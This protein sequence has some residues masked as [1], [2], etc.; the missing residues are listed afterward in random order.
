MYVVDHLLHFLSLHLQGERGG[1]GQGIRLVHRHGAQRLPRLW[2]RPFPAGTCEKQ[3]GRRDVWQFL[4]FS[5]AIAHHCGLTC[6]WLLGWKGKLWHQSHGHFKS[7]QSRADKSLRHIIISNVI[8]IPQSPLLRLYHTE[9][10]TKFIGDVLGLPKL[11]R[12]ADPLVRR[13]SLCLNDILII[14]IP[15]YWLMILHIVLCC[16]VQSSIPTPQTNNDFQG[17]ASINIFRP[18][19]GHNWHFDESAFSVTLMLQAILFTFLLWSCHNWQHGISSWLWFVL[20]FPK[21]SDQI[22][23]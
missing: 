19:T 8:I 23:L 11:Y 17:A 2:R 4:L 5:Q 10:F 3:V 12:L 20:T 1:G 22:E 6:L 9:S 21:T 16:K 7:T 18:G 13:L 14:C 15:S